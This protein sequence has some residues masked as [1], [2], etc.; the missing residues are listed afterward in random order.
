VLVLLTGRPYAVGWAMQRCA[1]VVQAF[2]PGEEGSGAVAGVLSGRVNPS[3]RL[4]VSLPRP[5]G[6]QPY[7][8]LHPPLGEGQEVT[9]LDSTPAAPF[10]F[11]LSY[12]TFGYS[13]L[14]TKP[15]GN[16]PRVQFTVTNTG[17]R[18]GTEVAQV[19]VG[20]LPTSAPTPVKQLAGSARLT[21]GS[22]QSKRVTVALDPRSLAYWDT[23]S[24]RWVTPG[25]DVAVL[26]GSSSRDIRL[27]GEIH[28]APST[29]QP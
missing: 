11:G 7:T 4:P 13:H 17:A 8:Y 3:G 19:Y 6:A 21:L 28:V 27:R 14:K 23:A 25:G 15:N 16:T 2:F 10:G 26:V 20:R 18:T 12:T 5:A 29:S 1:A 9:N 22:G 24:Q